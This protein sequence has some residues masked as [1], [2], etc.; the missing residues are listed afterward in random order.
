[1]YFKK[2]KFCVAILASA[3]TLSLVGINHSQLVNAAEQT[4]IAYPFRTGEV[5]LANSP[6]VKA[7]AQPIAS[8]DTSLWYEQIFDNPV[9]LTGATYVGLE[10]KNLNNSNPGFTVGVMS[11]GTRFGS[12][13]DGRPAYFV[14]E[15]GTV[16]QLSVLYASLNFGVN[17]SGMILIPLSSLSIVGW[18]DQSAT[19]SNATSIFLETNSVYN[20]N[21]SFMAGEAGFY[22]GDPFNGGKFTKLLDLSTSIKK[23][24]SSAVRYESVT[25]PET[26]TNINNI[27]GKTASYPFRKDEEAF[28]DAMIW[29]GTSAATGDSWQTLTVR[30]DQVADLTSASYLAVEYY[31]KAGTPGLTYAVENK[32]ARYSNVG[33]DGNDTYMLA[34]D[35][36]IKVAS[37]YLYDAS[38]VSQSGCLLIPM[39]YLK[40]QFGDAAN[41]LS[42]AE[43]FILT[44]NSLYNWG[45]EVGIGEIGYYTGR[46]QENNFTF[47]KLLDLTSGPKVGNYS[48][49]NNNPGTSLYRNIIERTVYGDTVINYT[50]TGKTNNSLGVWDGGAAGE[51]TM[52]K[53]SYGDDA[54][55]LE[56]TGARPGADAY[57]AFTLI[58]GANID[59]A[60]KKGVSLWARNDSDTE[61][62]FN[63]EFDVISTK[64]NVRA[65]FNVTGGNRFW[66]YDV[67]TG[68]QTIYMTRPCITLPVGFEGWVRVPFECFAQAQWSI[69]GA[70]AFQREFFMTEGCTVP[71]MCITVFSG[72]YTNKPFS[73]NKIGGY[74]TTPSFVSALVPADENRKD[75]PALMELEPLNG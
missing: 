73:I 1:M 9:D 34:Q 37:T 51:Q 38:N 72:T 56:C 50:A 21:F 53:D 60:G 11:N 30:F 25:F 13:I 69:D 29:V 35:G 14:H 41:T 24:K 44:T 65:R 32:G 75:I 40:L 62:S 66:L 68:K 31:A 45:Y 70:G 52:T 58:D 33:F 4:S 47:H 64:T 46:P 17:A 74:A 10:F 59:W 2:K 22:T 67:N 42:A 39:A 5:A 36:S 15:N 7:P 6:T 63:L 48:V 61:V 71:Y 8:G 27:A 12:Y 49:S 16:D 19:L 55:K 26:T 28:K 18:G 54:L 43:Q 23:N 20:Y 3:L 57:T